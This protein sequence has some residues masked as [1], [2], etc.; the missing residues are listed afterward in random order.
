MFYASFIRATRFRAAVQVSSPLVDPRPDRTSLLLLYGNK[1]H[2]C[3]SS[4]LQPR[5][6]TEGEVGGG[7]NSRELCATPFESPAI[8]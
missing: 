5:L 7:E 8:S 4:V 1:S 6:K 2:G 3:G